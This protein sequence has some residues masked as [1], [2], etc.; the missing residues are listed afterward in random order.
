MNQKVQSGQG[1]SSVPKDRKVDE[2]QRRQDRQREQSEVGKPP[3][4]GSASNSQPGSGP[5]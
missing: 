4:T 2:E 3:E 1:G 5:G